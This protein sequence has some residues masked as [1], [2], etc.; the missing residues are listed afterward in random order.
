MINTCITQKTSLLK[1]GYG[2]IYCTIRKK[3]ILSHRDAYENFWG[4][5]PK[6]FIVMHLCDNPSCIN[7]VHL[8]LGT[9]G[10]N[11]Q[12]AYKK[13]RYINQHTK[14]THCKNGHILSIKKIGKQRRCKECRKV[15][16]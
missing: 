6:G 5:I 12:D 9:R 14:K 10:N 1:S 16:G 8:R 3:M 15:Y 2:L 11:L 7:P 13:G 4:E